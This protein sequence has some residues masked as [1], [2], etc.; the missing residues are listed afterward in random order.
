M[1]DRIPIRSG[2]DRARVHELCQ[3]LHRLHRAVELAKNVEAE[4]G[5]GYIQR[6]TYTQLSKWCHPVPNLPDPQAVAESIS[7]ELFGFVIS[8]IEDEPA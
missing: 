7:Y 2:C 3:V 1:F 8:R 6:P 4:V 5:S